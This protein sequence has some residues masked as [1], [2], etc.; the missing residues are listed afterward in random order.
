MTKESTMLTIISFCTNHT[1]VENVVEYV[2]YMHYLK[3]MM[4][5]YKYITSI[6]LDV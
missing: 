5:S 1:L 2:T 3:T 4:M 6:Q